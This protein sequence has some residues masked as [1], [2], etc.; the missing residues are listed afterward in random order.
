M[1]RKIVF[2]N[3]KTHKPLNGKTIQQPIGGAIEK[4]PFKNTDEHKY[5]EN[6]KELKKM[7]KEESKDI[8]KDMKAEEQKIEKEK[9]EKEKKI[10]VKNSELISAVSQ[11]ILKD[12][13]NKKQKNEVEK[14]ENKDENMEGYGIA[15][16]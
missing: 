16:E 6:P 2:V 8:T 13:L 14:N 11:Q 7:I 3:S 12:I 1:S 5:H 4:H 9:K 10:S 15:I